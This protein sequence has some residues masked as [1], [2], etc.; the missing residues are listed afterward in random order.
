[1][2]LGRKMAF[3]ILNPQSKDNDDICVQEEGINIIIFIGKTKKFNTK[4]I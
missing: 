4:V 3:R 1:M 2:K